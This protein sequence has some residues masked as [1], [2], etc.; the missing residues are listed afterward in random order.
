MENKSINDPKLPNENVVITNKLNSA[1]K[2]GQSKGVL[3]TSIIG[4][5]ILLGLSLGA[6]SLYKRDHN[7]Q[8]AL[9]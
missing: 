6:Y 1:R 4:L 3:I 5:V 9:M 8:L 2:E 7:T